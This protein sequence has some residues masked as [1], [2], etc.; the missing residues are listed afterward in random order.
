[1]NETTCSLTEFAWECIG[2]GKQNKVMLTSIMGGMDHGGLQLWPEI[3]LVV[4]RRSPERC[5]STMH[6]LY[7]LPEENSKSENY[8]NVEICVN[9]YLKQRYTHLATGLDVSFRRTHVSR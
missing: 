3:M 8:T 5:H 4:R 2:C 9:S 7:S 6:I 1:M